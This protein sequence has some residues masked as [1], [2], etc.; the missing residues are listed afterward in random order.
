MPAGPLELGA[1]KCDGSKN[2]TPGSAA[3]EN[4][5]PAPSDWVI[6]SRGAKIGKDQL[7]HSPSM[8]TSNSFSPFATTGIQPMSDNDSPAA[9]NPLVSKLKVVDEKEGKDLK[10]KMSNGSDHPPSW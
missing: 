1:N 2:A 6:V 5:A 3:P 10:H 9:D 8:A 7:A 4:V